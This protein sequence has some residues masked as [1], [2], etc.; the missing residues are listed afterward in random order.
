[1]KTRRVIGFCVVL[2]GF[3]LHAS[4]FAQTIPDCTVQAEGVVGGFGPGVSGDEFGGAFSDIGGTETIIWTHRGPGFLLEMDALPTE[5]SCRT[6]GGL[7]GEAAGT[8]VLNGTPDPRFFIQV[9]DNRPP[10]PGFIPV[11]ARLLQEPVREHSDHVRSFETPQA[12]IIPATL[13]VIT[14]NAGAGSAR[15]RLDNHTCRYVGDGGSN[16]A[17]ERC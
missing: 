14:G 4:V 2:L 15:L 17:F 16:Y 5:I 10:Q 9:A 13:P 11:C 6:N 1:M 8:G 7:I 12:V 3:G